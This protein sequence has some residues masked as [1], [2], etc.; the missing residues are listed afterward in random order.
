MI[1]VLRQRRARKLALR[2]V[3]FVALPTALAGVYYGAVASDQYESVSQFTI[4]AADAPR[5]MALETVLGSIG[6]SAAPRET[7]SV[8]EHI[9]SRDMLARLDEEQGF[10]AHYRDSGADP[11][12]RL[13]RDTSFEAA[14]AYYLRKVRVDY[15]GV[16]GM[17]TLKVRAF[18]AERAEAFAKTILTASE[19]VVNSLSE[20]A[21]LDQTRYA[22]TELDRAEVRLKEARERLTTLQQDRRELDPSQT[23]SAALTLR[24]SLE[25]ELAR[26]RSELMQAESY[27][28]PSAP[29]VVALREKVRSIS[30]QVAGESARMVS[31]H[32][33]KGLE[34]SIAEFEAAHVEKEFAQKAYE[35]ALTSLE[36]ARIDASRQ[37]RYLATVVQPSVPDEATHP[38]RWYA[39]LTVF[40]ASL[41]FMGIGWLGIAAVKE[42][43]R[44]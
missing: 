33:E 15:D 22:R 29:Q 14:Y 34:R 27:M 23:A 10:I 1:R 26:A 19:E 6:G 16:S 12:S 28:N 41:L 36:G 8:R 13:W 17:L 30:A 21:R 39:I 31:P 9:L 43:A 7:L 40:V 35:S 11:L 4:Y 3:L 24:T 32:N 37:H 42:H 20:Q 25:A 44:L 5:A 38:K 18:A 2:S